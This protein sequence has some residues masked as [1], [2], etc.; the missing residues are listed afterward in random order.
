M[1]TRAT[2][3]PLTREQQATVTKWL[4]LACKYTLWGLIQRGLRHYEDEAEGLAAEAL[5][6]AVRVWEPERGPFPA[7]LKWWVWSTL[8][9]F[10]A[11]GARTVHQS[12]HAEEYVD[13]WSL[14]M[15][16][17]DGYHGGVTQIVTFQDL[18]VDDSVSDP[19]E[20][21]DARRLARA[22]P[23]VLRQRMSRE[24]NTNKAREYAAESVSIWWKRLQA[25]EYGEIPLQHFA[26]VLG[27]CR[28][29]IRQREAQV[30]REFEEWAREL[31]EEAA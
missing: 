24:A 23:I 15:P 17:T 7:C 12:E 13:A 28:E 4:P 27:V 11:H 8:N 1:S 18:L 20:D 21:V 22:V 3:K 5:L 29:R 25:E 6:D 10:S 31:R 2:R 30:Q 9:K 14:N 16:A 19:T 26:D